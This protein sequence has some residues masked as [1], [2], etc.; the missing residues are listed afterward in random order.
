MLSSDDEKD[1][2][3]VRRSQLKR[4]ISSSNS[5]NTVLDEYSSKE[6]KRVGYTSNSLKVK[7]L[8]N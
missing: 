2:F 8:K 7:G 5:I 3:E 4:S 6:S 1:D